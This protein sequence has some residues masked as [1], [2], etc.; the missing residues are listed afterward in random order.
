MPTSV[1]RVSEQLLTN[2][3]REFCRLL[4]DSCTVLLH[5][6]ITLIVVRIRRDI[7]GFVFV[8]EELDCDTF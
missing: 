4:T 2:I 6:H 5:T 7:K 8:N 1:E 3:L